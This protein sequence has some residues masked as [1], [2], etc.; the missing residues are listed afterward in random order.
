LPE[1]NG[2]LLSIFGV[3][4]LAWTGISAFVVASRAIYDRRRRSLRRVERLLDRRLREAAAELEGGEAVVSATLR[5][6]PRGTVERVA[7]DRSNPEW[8]A[9]PV[10]RFAVECWGER[11]V[12]SA[13]GHTG[14]ATRWRRVAAVQILARAGHPRTLELLSMAT[15]DSDTEVGVQRS[16]SSGACVTWARPSC[17]CR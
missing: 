2:V 16:R 1:V 6:L 11:L 8:L 15:R 13:E 17:W 7:A 10:A 4:L 12:R 9:E 5:R 3:V 14:E